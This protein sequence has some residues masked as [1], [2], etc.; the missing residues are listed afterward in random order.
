MFDQPVVQTRADAGASEPEPE[1]LTEGSEPDDSSE[2]DDDGSEPDDLAERED[3]GRVTSEQP[4]CR[5][6]ACNACVAGAMCAG[7][8]LVSWCHPASGTCAQACDP[9][10]TA[11]QVGSCPAPQRCSPEL[12]LCVACVTNDDCG[13]ASPV[14]DEDRCVQCVID[15]DCSGREDDRLCMGDERRCVECRDNSDCTDPQ[16]PICSDEYECE[17]ED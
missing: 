6:D 2:P 9:A 5:S 8:S 4:D 3:A 1:P 13:G 14:C 7:S 17:D 12:G 16:R 15:A 11:A 10:A